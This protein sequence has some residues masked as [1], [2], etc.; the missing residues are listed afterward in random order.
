MVGRSGSC[1]ARVAV[2]ALSLQLAPGEIYALLGPNGAGKTTT[3]N[4][5]L[6]FVAADAG[7]IEVGGTSVQRDLLAARAFPVDR[8][9]DAGHL[10]LT[11]V[12]RGLRYGRLLALL[13][14][15]LL[16]GLL[17]ILLRFVLRVAGRHFGVH[18]HVDGD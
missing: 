10:A 9:D 4:L 14:E 2:D 16:R 6:G 8:E 3:I 7:T 11:I 18:V 13:L 1:G 12:L 15:V 17:K 5:I